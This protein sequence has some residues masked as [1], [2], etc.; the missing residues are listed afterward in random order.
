MELWT[1]VLCS[2]LML[3]SK[4]AMYYVWSSLKN[5]PG[6]AGA[7]KDCPSY[8]CSWL[9]QLSHCSTGTSLFILVSWAWWD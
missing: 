1:L 5:Q 3:C 8:H 6:P 2:C 4:H 9:W 7:W